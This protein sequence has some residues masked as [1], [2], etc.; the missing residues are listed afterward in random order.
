MVNQCKRLR[1]HRLQTK[2]EPL[3]REVLL[4]ACF[5][6]ARVTQGIGPLEPVWASCRACC[7]GNWIINIFLCLLALLPFIF[8]LEIKIAL[9]HSYF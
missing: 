5:Q 8:S 2:A 6:T 3:L 9:F 1:S 4:A 7:L